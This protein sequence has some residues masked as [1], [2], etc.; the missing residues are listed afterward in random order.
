[1]FKRKLQGAYLAGIGLVCLILMGVFAAGAQD[2]P[3][4]LTV[5]VPE[6]GRP[7]F[8][9]P[10][11]FQAFEAEYGV[12]V[13]LRRKSSSSFISPESGDVVHV[14]EYFLRPEQIWAGDFL[15]LAPLIAAD[16]GFDP[17]DF[18]PAA[19]QSFQW[20]GG[21]WALPYAFD[22]RFVVYNPELFDAIGFPYPDETWT[23]DDYVHAEQVFIE[24]D[25]SGAIT[26]PGFFFNSEDWL[27]LFRSV[28]GEPLYDSNLPPQPALL[29][30][31]KEAVLR[32]MAE[33]RRDGLLNG[34]QIQGAI[35]RNRL[36]MR[37]GGSWEL[38]STRLQD[39]NPAAGALLPGGIAG[40]SVAGFAVSGGTAYPELAYALAKY[41]TNDPRLVISWDTATPA[42]RS[43]ALP[44]A[45]SSQSY[46][47][48]DKSDANRAFLRRA[49]DHALPASELWYGHWLDSTV[50]TMAFPPE[51]AALVLHDAED[52]ARAALQ[53]SLTRRGTQVIVIPTPVP[54]PNLEV[55]EV[56]LNFGVVVYERLLENE[57][58][59]DALI[60][61]FTAADPAVRQITIGLATLNDVSGLS[62]N[63]DCYY[64]PYNA[65][66]SGITGVINLDPLLNSDPL[67][68]PADFADGIL[69]QVTQESKIWAYP[70]TIQPQV[71][72]YD[73][74]QFDRFGIPAPEN[75]WSIDAFADAVKTLESP[76]FVPHNIGGNYILML[77]AAYGGL[78]MDYRTT[79]P[80]LNFTDPASVDAVRQVLDLAKA[81]YIEYH[82][83]FDVPFMFTGSSVTPGTP[84]YDDSLSLFSIAR[85]RQ[86]DRESLHVTTFP[87]G[88]RYTPVTYEIGTTFISDQAPNPEAC[89][90]WLTTL[91]EH[92][93]LFTAM[94]ARRS[95]LARPEVTAIFGADLTS[96][97]TAFERTLDAPDVVTFPVLHNFS[98]LNNLIIEY[99]LYRA[100]SRY[101]QENA[102][103]E[104]ELATAQ[105]LGM[106]YRACLGDL[107]PLDISTFMQEGFSTG[108]GKKLIDCGVQIDPELAMLL[109]GSE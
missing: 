8:D 41:L 58:Y 25:A 92:P 93:E 33:Y 22:L 29:T 26:R 3:I 78:L 83:P 50:R 20:N 62:E 37:M 36:P 10:A 51:T 77:A 86:E 65:V 98:T 66:N 34:V 21:M 85:Y 68:D 89:Y 15:D 32:Q 6:Y 71:I 100:F 56:A 40:I 63:Y 16:T 91:G 46:F 53:D 61:T 60:K 12:K 104:T 38:D 14:D 19:W 97:Y 7:A 18:F 79:P 23:L 54:T 75:G 64:M 49:L 101:V 103:L 106:D 24:R 44:D 82:P 84:L 55:D 45:D 81:G 27:L 42:R 39:S 76:A 30:P 74:E 107:P 11:L 57:A 47:F 90:R 70:V 88:S 52:K 109:G 80:T 4:I 108:Y 94:P 99:W 105:M 5:F 102:D 96:L 13:V 73:Q 67:F 69:Q 43:V 48:P 28:T 1:M 95:I 35:M 2:S 59:W 9:D 87:Y 72:W 17:D 31:A